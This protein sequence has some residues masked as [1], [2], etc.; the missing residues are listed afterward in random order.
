MPP[1]TVSVDSDLVA[2]LAPSLLDGV[3]RLV[4]PEKK[5]NA[6]TVAAVRNAVEFSVLFSNTATGTLLASAVLLSMEAAKELL[7]LGSLPRFAVAVCDALPGAGSP[8]EFVLYGSP[9]GDAAVTT[10]LML[11]TDRVFAAHSVA[12]TDFAKHVAR[13]ALYARDKL[14]AGHKPAAD[15]AAALTEPK[16]AG[17]KRDGEV[18]LY[19]EMLA[20]IHGVSRQRALVIA[21]LYP[22]MGALVDAAAADPALPRLAEAA[23][24]AQRYGPQNAKNVAAA[25]SEKFDVA[26][27]RAP[28]LPAAA[29]APAAALY[30]AVDDDDDDD[31]LLGM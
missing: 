18:L 25:L 9:A 26:C 17:A 4:E 2:D 22:T 23:F 1:I 20:Q 14:D 7:A 13:A 12:P 8:V 19:R 21:A 30:A 15:D 6:I 5:K 31:S 3:R 24:G 29:A 28:P 10:A 16:L 11:S 27:L